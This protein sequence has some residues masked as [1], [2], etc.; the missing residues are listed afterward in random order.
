MADQE[1][2][3]AEQRAAILQRRARL[4]ACAVMTGV[5]TAPSAC[6]KR[7]LSPIGPEPVA[8]AGAVAGSGLNACLSGASGNG[9]VP[10]MNSGGSSAG[11]IPVD[12]GMGGEETGGSGGAT[13]AAGGEGGGEPTICLSVR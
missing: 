13:T 7:C 8:G 1:E 9:G 3:R 10:P 5:I 11:S 4:V 6:S 2:D 12:L